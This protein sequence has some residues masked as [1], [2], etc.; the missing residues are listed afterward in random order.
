VCARR[1]PHTAAGRIEPARRDNRAT[2]ALSSPS[3]DL[4]GSEAP[5][6][7]RRARAVE[8][9]APDR[10]ARISHGRRRHR[11]RRRPM[12]SVDPKRHAIRRSLNEFL[13]E[14]ADNCRRDW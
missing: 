1:C 5:R 10:R 4:P 12:E 2:L 7:A 9:R 8:D 14:P 6:G 13:A 3:Y 11:G